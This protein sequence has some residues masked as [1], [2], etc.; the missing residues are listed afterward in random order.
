VRQLI[1]SW[2]PPVHRGV[3]V[4]W[5]FVCVLVPP[6]VLMLLAVLFVSMLFWIFASAD[7][8]TARSDRLAFG[9]ELKVVRVGMTREQ[10]YELGF[11]NLTDAHGYSRPKPTLAD[12]HPTV[13]ASFP[14]VDRIIC[15]SFDARDRIAN[16]RV[17]GSGRCPR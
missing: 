3:G 8:A 7:E 15:I 17:T 16:V 13:V 2:F 4:G 10:L 9:R 6:A 1:S 14:D 11:F 5:F 12:S